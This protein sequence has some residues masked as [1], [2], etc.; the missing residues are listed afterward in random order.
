MEIIESENWNYQLIKA[1]NVYKLFI[2][3][4]TVGV[5]EKEMKL[6]EQEID[7][8]KREGCA[9]LKQ[10]VNKYRNG[11]QYKKQ[12]RTAEVLEKPSERDKI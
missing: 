5:Y 6:T 4:G 2:V 9:Y 10:L 8:Y 7:G 11:V 1:K 12:G 3:C